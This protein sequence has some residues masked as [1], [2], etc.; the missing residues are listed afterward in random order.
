MN[1]ISIYN[2]VFNTENNIIT[3]DKSCNIIKEKTN[4]K[5][6]QIDKTQTQIEILKTSITNIQRCID[7]CKSI[8]ECYKK[9]Y[10]IHCLSMLYPNI[11]IDDYCME[12]I[13]N[14]ITNKT[15]NIF[16]SNDIYYLERLLKQKKEI[17]ERYENRKPS[18][19]YSYL[20]KREIQRR[21]LLGIEN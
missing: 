5:I 13:Y 10:N 15:L 17:I 9:T 12:K 4:L 16:T 1:N 18:N 11:S 21:K 6:K 7:T 20:S 19:N 14:T 8:N 3:L 2:V